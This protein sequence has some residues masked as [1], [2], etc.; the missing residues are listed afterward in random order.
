VDGEPEATMPAAESSFRRL[1]GTRGKSAAVG[2]VLKIEN[3]A[4]CWKLDPLYAAWFWPLM[5]RVN[6]L[7]LL[8]PEKLL[9]PAEK[10]DSTSPPVPPNEDEKRTIL[11]LKERQADCAR[12]YTL[13]MRGKPALIHKGFPTR[14]ANLAILRNHRGGDA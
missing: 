1:A 8:L 3:G 7:V 12:V 5:S 9:E 13:A 4:A 11:Q 6:D 14:L 2:E 10:G